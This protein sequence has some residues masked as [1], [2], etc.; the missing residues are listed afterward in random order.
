MVFG[1]VTRPGL[2]KRNCVRNWWIFDGAHPQAPLSVVRCRTVSS[3]KEG[4]GHPNAATAC[5]LARFGSP[6][7]CFSTFHDARFRNRRDSSLVVR[8]LCDKQAVKLRMWRFFLFSKRWLVSALATLG[9]SSTP[10]AC[11]ADQR[12]GGVF[13]NN[14][15]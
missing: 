4:G 10:Q 1:S 2:Y 12:R 15:S 7:S 8:L 14:G 9:G 5:R 11:Q 3:S 13:R 6:D